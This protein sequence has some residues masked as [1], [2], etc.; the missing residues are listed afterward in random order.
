MLGSQQQQRAPLSRKDTLRNLLASLSLDIDAPPSSPPLPQNPNV[1][2]SSEQRP[3]RL[4]IPVD[5]AAITSTSPS[6][7]DSSSL[8]SQFLSYLKKHAKKGYRNVKQYVKN[9][10]KG[11]SFE[12]V[13]HFTKLDDVVEADMKDARK[14]PE[15]LREAEISRKN[16]I[17][18]EEQRFQQ[19]RKERMRVPFAKFIGV[20][21]E[22]VDVRDI[23]II[24]VGG[25]GGGMKAMIATAGFLQG[26]EE[27]GFFDLVMYISGVSGSCWTLGNLYTAAEGSPTALVNHFTR[28]CTQHPFDLEH[29]DRII[30][31]DPTRIY[32]IFGGLMQKYFCG[33]PRGI[34]DLY[35]AVLV[36]HFFHHPHD[37]AFR[38]EDFKFSS[39]IPTFFEGGR[40]PLPIYT[41]VRHA[42][43]WKDRKFDHED[44]KMSIEEYENMTG[45][46][47]EQ[48]Q[49]ELDKA[50]EDADMDEK[51]KLVENE[52]AWWQWFEFSPYQIGS[53]ELDVW[54]PTWAFGRRFVGGVAVDKV[55]EID[56]S[57]IF[58]LTASAMC[59]PFSKAL[60]TVSTMQE[61]GKNSLTD[62]IKSLT[63]MLMAPN[64]SEFVKSILSKHFIH[65]SFN[66]NP[67][68]D[69]VK[70]QETQQPGLW[71][72]KRIQW[73][74]AGVD[75]NQ[76]F[77]AFTREGRDVDIIF[78]LDSS[79]DVEKDVI[80][81][82]FEA[83][84]KRVNVQITPTSPEPN[85][86]RRRPSGACNPPLIPGSESV[87]TT[88]SEETLP[89]KT[90][91]P[92]EIQAFFLDRYCQT[93]HATP[94]DP[95]GYGPHTEPNLRREMDLVYMPNLRNG[96]VT[97]E[98]LF[99]PND[100]GFSK[101]E[102]KE[103]ESRGLAESA[104]RNF[105]EQVERIRKL[106]GSVW[107]RKRMER[108]ETVG[109]L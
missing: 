67:L 101:L 25:S 104:R 27:A 54:F 4:P 108:M 7:S 105:L 62:G 58:G 87:S 21:V 72:S 78:V 49:E 41:A 74:D 64:A 107:E 85:T 28:V 9:S 43:P 17:C 91:P 5:Q 51:I 15:I 6:D 24:G 11:S 75:N 56:F 81:P 1:P 37:R 53:E 70:G 2:L 99:G 30:S 60:S 8:N 69:P 22:E 80:P 59:L 23:P 16:R 14:N 71:N 52:E 40:H 42:R 33:L 20:A 19:Q 44:T 94:L 18:D 13:E 97:R 47:L 31:Q 34:V 83:F 102:W 82:D 36:A 35:G 95:T 77:Y 39:Q 32:L 88:P 12:H 68:Y 10:L 29:L 103:W 38:E 46:K 89:T 106:V 84:S 57:T 76:P 26:M 45:K 55:P 61:G 109:R 100:V 98:F 93:F 50:E 86:G 92:S 63:G 48:I 66:W 73:I 79:T 3:D 96:S 65:S 90:T